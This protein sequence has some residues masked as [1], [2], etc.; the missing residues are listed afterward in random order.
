MKKSMVSI[1]RHS[2][3]LGNT[4][5]PSARTARCATM[6]D[7]EAEELLLRLWRASGRMTPRYLVTVS[8]R[9]HLGIGYSVLVIGYSRHGIP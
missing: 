8:Q 7:T 4:I 1:I 6:R 9:T 2:P 3:R 5:L